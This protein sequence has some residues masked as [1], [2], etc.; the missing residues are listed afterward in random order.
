R[1]LE[2]IQPA[3]IGQALSLEASVQ[4]VL[5]ALQ[6]GAHSAVLVMEY[7]DPQVKDDATAESLGITE[8][9][10]AETS[11]F[12]GSD[13]ARIQNISAAASSFHGLLIPPGATFSMA[14]QLT[15]ISLEN[16]YAEALI[17]VGGETVKGVGGGVCQVSTTLFRTAFF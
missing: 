7:V 11:Y 4:T 16:G 10:I 6:S 9:V 5:D 3:T 12:F 13:D 2:V 1:Q 8:L 15:D 17:I 14:S